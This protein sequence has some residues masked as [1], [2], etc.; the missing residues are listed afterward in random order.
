ML[1]CFWQILSARTLLIKFTYHV[2]YHISVFGFPSPGWSQR[3]LSYQRCFFFTKD[4]WLYVYTT[5][6]GCVFFIGCLKDVPITT[7][8]LHIWYKYIILKV[9]S[10][11]DPWL[12]LLCYN[13]IK[14][15][16]FFIIMSKQ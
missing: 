4:I 11:M 13:Q 16:P 8:V 15:N 5:Y 9:N 1:I 12:I 7:T 10:S 6:C 3:Y 14:V 2:I